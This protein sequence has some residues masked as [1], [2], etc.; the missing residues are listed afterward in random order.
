MLRLSRSQWTVLLAAWLGWGFDI[1]DGLLLNYVAPNAIPTLLGLTIGSAAARAATVYWTGLLTSVLLVGWAIGGILFGK[2]CDRVGRST[3]LLV[4]MVIYAIGTFSC[5]FAPNIGTL[6]LF[7][8]IASLG[9]GGEWAA[10]ASM[11][12]EVV[13]ERSRVEAGALLYTSA[14]LGLFLATGVN[15]VIA[16]GWLVDQPEL[17]WRV[18]FLSGL[19]PAAVAFLVRLFLKEPE[20][21]QQAS[22]NQKP[23]RIR[24][25]FTP[26]LRRSTLSG[27]LMAVVALLAWWSCNA[28]IPLVATG[29]AR[30]AA[31]GAGHPATPALVEHW[32]TAITNA[33]NTG[34]LLGTLLT[35]PAA[36]LLGRRWM[37]AL[38]FLASALV[39]TTSFGL[40][41]PA[42]LALWCGLYFAIGVSV[43]GIFGSFSF[44]LPELFPTRLRATGAGFC[45]NS[46]RII[47][48]IGPFLVG[49]I[50]ASKANVLQGAFGVLFVIGFVPLIG[51]LAMPL[52]LETR[53]RTLAD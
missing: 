53:G 7:R 45:Y 34:G 42:D 26:A 6:V 5:A 23:P 43:F 40:K 30:E 41:Q 8:L 13:P 33:F 1:F 48:A 31:A 52:V 51:L 14:P 47:T 27:V 15:A 50:A 35:I 28:F 2:L 12:A 3:T 24:Q 21:W 4:T 37:F 39:M 32:K 11:V 49:S 10:G 38:Y 22:A 18:V 36:K 29:L 9:I 16:G 17:S 46:G 25:L 19:L 20:R 44:Y